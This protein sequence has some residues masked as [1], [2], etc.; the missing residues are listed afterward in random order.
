MGS[1]NSIPEEPEPEYGFKINGGAVINDQSG[2]IKYKKDGFDI[3]IIPNW[4]KNDAQF[5]GSITQCEGVTLIINS[6]EINVSRLRENKISDEEFTV[7]GCKF[8]LSSS[9]YSLHVSGVNGTSNVDIIFDNDTKEVI[10]TNY[11]IKFIYCTF[12]GRP[13]TISNGSYSISVGVVPSV[14]KFVIR[15]ENKSCF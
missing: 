13:T 4:I 1:C 14:G 2:T 10:F 12:A 7:D 9:K 11:D 6:K 5:E 3:Q 8:T 15:T